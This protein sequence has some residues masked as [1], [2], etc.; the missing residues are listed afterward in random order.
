MKKLFLLLLLVVS[1]GMAF[2]QE[3]ADTLQLRSVETR[4]GNTYVGIVISESGDSLI[5][6]TDKLGLLRFSK[7]DIRSLNELKR[8]NRS[9]GEYWLPNPQSSRYFWAPNGY[10]LKKGEAYFQ[11]IWVMYNQVSLGLTDNFSLGGGIMP[12]FLVGVE[13]AP[14]W[15]VPKLS[16]P[17][18]KEKINLGTGAFLGSVIGEDTG[19]F[20]LLYGTATFGSRDKNFSLG[21]AYGFADGEWMDKPV[22]NLSTMVRVGPKGYFISENYILTVDN[23]VAG[24]ISVGGRSM[25]R[26]IGLDYSLWIPVG[27]DLRT[28]FAFPF[29]GITVP[30]NVTKKM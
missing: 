2:G 14:V 7:M 26:K 16:I 11:N 25:I 20:G 21:M 1:L 8:A 30:L 27:A 3:P 22:I 29:L 5:L 12:L 4:D 19:V 24:I 28:F 18:V 13:A 10:G 6:K 15:L 9:R 23:Q 17:L